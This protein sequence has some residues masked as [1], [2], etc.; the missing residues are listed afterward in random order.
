M[1]PAGL[2]LFLLR[3]LLLF[4]ASLQ[5]LDGFFRAAGARDSELLAA[6]FIVLDEEL[7]KL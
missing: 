7:F 4:N 6:L 5:K 1:R 3:S 2:T